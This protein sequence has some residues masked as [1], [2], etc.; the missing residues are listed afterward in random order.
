L[1]RLLNFVTFLSIVK[2]H[3]QVTAELEA[4]K[5]SES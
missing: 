4:R 5:I 1:R 2:N 3:H